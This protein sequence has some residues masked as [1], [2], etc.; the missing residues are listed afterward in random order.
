[1][2]NR[3]SRPVRT[4]RV[5]LMA[6][7]LAAGG[8][9][10]S[11]GP[12][13]AD[14]ESPAPDGDLGLTATAV[15]LGVAATERNIRTG[16]AG[17]LPD[18]TPVAYALSDGNPVSF[19]VINMDTGELISSFE[20]PPKSVGAF[21][22]IAPDGMVYFSVRDGKSSLVHRYDPA[23]DEVEFLIES[24]TGEAVTRSMVVGEDGL[25]YGSTYPNARAF[26]Y[27]PE[28]GE[29]V[30]FGSVTGDDEY[31]WGLEESEGI[32]YVGTGIGAGH[33]MT[34]DTSTGEIAELPLPPEADAALTYF[35]EFQQ[36][37]DLIAMAF[38]PGISDGTNTLF[39]DTVDEEW[40][41]EGAIPRFLDL[42]GP[43]TKAT[44]DGTM[45]YMSEDEIWSFD[46]A[47][48]S[49]EPTG[50]AA[51]DLDDDTRVI[52]MVMTGEGDA[53]TPVLIGMNNDGST[54]RFAP[55]TGEHE[56]FE[57]VVPGAPLTAHTVTSG[58]DDRI[59]VSTYLGPGAIGRYDPATEEITTLSG[60]GQASSLIGFGDQIVVGSYPG[61]VVHIGDPEQPWDWGTNPAQAFRL[62]GDDQ[63][64]VIALATDDETVAMGTVSDYGVRGGSLTLSDMNGTVD[65]YRDLVDHQSVTSLTFGSD[66]LIYAGTGV[67]G[68]L[69]SQNSPLDAH[70]VV[71]DPD[72]REVVHAQ[73]P[74]PDNDTVAALTFQ[75]D[76]LWGLTN[77][78]I[79]FS[80]DPSTQTVT[81][82]TDLG[83]GQSPSPWGLASTLQAHPADGLL[84]G[85]AGENL[86]A[87]DPAT[88]EFQ[89]LSEAEY[90]RITI[91]ESG[92]IYAI[93]A[94]NLYR[95]DIE[96][97]AAECTTTIDGT[98]D[99]ALTV[100]E[101]VTC[102]EGGTV[103]GATV[104]REGASLIA[105]DATLTGGLASTSA[106]T[107]EVTD[108]SI[109][110]AVSIVGTTGGT[111]ISGTEISGPLACS[112]NDPAPSNLGV[113]NMVSGPRAGQC[114]EL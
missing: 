37:G 36:V 70:L 22:A 104:V 81:S 12:A 50:W 86:F 43:F 82:T 10:L 90:K 102:I 9:L 93:G 96:T 58:P 87:F 111:T 3:R 31:G 24:P 26:T 17:V 18:G 38:S 73:V 40:A 97:G 113:P 71:F 49:V 88:E 33:V 55:T 68:G 95:I 8:G 19:N 94:T 35:Y 21:P 100:R 52:D 54:W 108:S 15:D 5:A 61:G 1:M 105:H 79:V 28:T 98:H 107:I 66:G 106:A 84:Y 62:I 48:C 53:A 64:R 51:A 74:V 46:S 39:W 75:G 59:Y 41:C 67:R 56:T 34:V 76:T 7:A 91:T 45:F 2:R 4:R 30:D 109:A 110:G 114:S 99:G 32:M 27:D 44:P 16:A 63:D 112:G 42:N 65:V 29:V 101:G 72:S 103:H 13:T 85:I 11:T 69:S 80:F 20:L 23:T 57:S 25:I 89:F 83:T 47:D 60:P 77:T 92:D 14:A 6:A 78:G